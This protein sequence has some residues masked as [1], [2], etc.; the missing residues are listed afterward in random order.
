[1]IIVI[2]VIGTD[3]GIKEDPQDPIPDRGQGPMTRNTGTNTSIA[4]DIQNIINRVII[5]NK[6]EG[7]STHNIHQL[8]HL[9]LHLKKT[10][11]KNIKK[12]RNIGTRNNR[13]KNL[14]K[15]KGK[16][17][18][19]IRNLNRRIGLRIQEVIDFVFVNKNKFM[20]F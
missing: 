10:Q 2:D 17:K 3:E 15:S 19:R 13:V 5:T 9:L 7:E 20:T 1:M 8:R 4:V 6:K 11:V 16:I 18:N 12:I 14:K